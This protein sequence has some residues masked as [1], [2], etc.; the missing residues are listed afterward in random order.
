ALKVLARVSGGEDREVEEK[1]RNEAEPADVEE[2]AILPVALR[3]EE[4]LAR[5][6]EQQKDADR[7]HDADRHEQRRAG[8]ADAARETEDQRRQRRPRPRLDERQRHGSG[9]IDRTEARPARIE[10]PIH[11]RE[12]RQESPE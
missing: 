5:S 4:Q 2:S 9:R 8:D 11:G 1:L 6:A 10:E 12:N 3:L 7:D